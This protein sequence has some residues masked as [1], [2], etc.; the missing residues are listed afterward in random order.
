MADNPYDIATGYNSPLIQDYLKHSNSAIG[1]KRDAAQ[2]SID[3]SR[4][5]MYDVL[6]RQQLQTERDIAKRRIMAQRSGM[7]SSQLA[8]QEM[9]NIMTGQ[10]GAQQIAQQYRQEQ[11]L[12]EQQFAGAEDENMA[13][14]IEMLNANR[15]TVASLDTQKYTASAI[16]QVKELYPS[17]TPEQLS[18]LARQY[19]GLD[20]SSSEASK[21]SGL[22]S[23][24]RLFTGD[25]PL[26]GKQ[27]AE[28]EGTNFTW[29]GSAPKK[30][31]KYIEEFNKRKGTDYSINFWGTKAK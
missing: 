2:E 9:Q 19:L 25:K 23:E 13:G 27:W 21:I 1:A 30:Y 16:A 20:I 12:A 31:K 24:S 6:G 3:L 17:A 22:G 15:N 28:E 7:T 26:S 10:M 29:D 11:A 14:L 4:S 18:I 8:A 5:T